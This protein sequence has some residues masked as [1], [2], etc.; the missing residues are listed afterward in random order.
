VWK[1]DTNQPVYLVAMRG[2]FVGSVAKVP[3]GQAK[4]KGTVL[5][6][7][8]DPTTGRIVDWGIS[9]SVPDLSS[10]G[11]VEQIG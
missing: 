4:P 3:S 1:V 11:T 9:D 7:T 6:A 10:L 8:V 2:N 5:T